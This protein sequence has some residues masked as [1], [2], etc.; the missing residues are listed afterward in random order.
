MKKHEGLFSL[1]IILG[2][3][4]CV[5]LG[6]RIF[7]KAAMG[8]SVLSGIGFT[9]MLEAACVTFLM[10]RSLRRLPE[11]FLFLAGAACVALAFAI[12]AFA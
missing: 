5:L 3:P 1:I 4:L 8:L 6:F 12:D 11:S 10:D 9:L 2:C 7:G